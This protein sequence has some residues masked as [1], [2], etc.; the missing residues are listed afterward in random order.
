MKNSWKLIGD[1]LDND[2][3]RVLLA[4]RGI[5]V[6][7]PNEFL[8]PPRPSLELAKRLLGF[9]EEDFEKISSIFTN[10]INN[11]RPII[12]HGDYDVDG[13][14]ATAII[15]QAIYHDLG[16]KN[17]RPFIP[18]RFDHGY[19]L[20]EES[21]DAIVKDLSLYLTNNQELKAENPALLVTVDCGIT[22]SH[23]VEYAK[24]KGFEVLIVDHHVKPETIPDCSIFW[25]DRVCAAGLSYIISQIL[26]H[27][28]TDFLELA[29]L[30]TV[31]DLQP[32]LGFNRSLTK[33]GLEELNTTKNVGLT[34]LKKVSGIEGRNIGT[35]E[36]GWIL[37]P[38]LNASG[39]LENALESLRL[40]CTKS[41]KQALEIAEKLDS[42][43]LERQELTKT[44]V[45]LAL[46]I[47]QG[48]SLSKINVAVHKQFHEGIIGLVAGKLVSHL[49]TPAVVISKGE[50]FSKASA[51]SVEGFNIVEFLRSLGPHF[52]NIGG[53]SGAAGFTICTERIEEFLKALNRGQEN[54]E[55]PPPLLRVEK[56]LKLEEITGDLLEII[57]KLAP[58]GIG[59]QEPLFLSRKVPI[60]NVTFVGSEKSHLK[61]NLGVNGKSYSAIFFGKGALYKD[62][63]AGDCIDVVYNL[64]EDNWNG[65]RSVSLKIRDLDKIVGQKNG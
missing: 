24:S 54:L 22:A 46:S 57:N 38:R 35:F 61:L 28:Q 60:Q 62:L 63:V 51:R 34:A 26:N 6:E 43:N 17:C 44:A 55:I 21:I 19:G 25:S 18:N 59:N 65:G 41:E 11:C 30:G 8:E 56:E 52:E 47:T 9:N 23:E 53:H 4:N 20:S 7:G 40:L 27:G 50:E 42:L 5:T 10:A 29:A 64:S 33:F 48:E 45:D 1:V 58:F 36:I 37:A 32:L 31:A 13:I 14:C 15:W 3:L 49:G 16:Y 39:R 2:V 12:I